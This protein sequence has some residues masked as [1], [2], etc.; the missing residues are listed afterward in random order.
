MATNTQMSYAA[1]S[2]E[3]DAL[4]DLLD[5]GYIRI[6]NGS[7]PSNADTAVSSQ[8]LLAELRVNATA[9]PAA[10][11]G[12]LTFNAITA[13]ASANASGTATWFR[14]LKSD[15][16]TVIMD[17]T[18]GTAGANMNLASVTLTAGAQV[19]VTSWTHTIT[20]A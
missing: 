20:R 13:D 4:S 17:G 12:V 5:N 8:T 18:V 7:Q 9:A 15:G 11:N 6:Y 2:A 10:V 14:T 1:V 3:A 16:S 19:Q